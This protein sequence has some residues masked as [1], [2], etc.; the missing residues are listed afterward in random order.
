MNLATLVVAAV[1]AVCG[2]HVESHGVSVDLPARWQPATHSLTPQLLDPHELLSAGTFRL[3]YRELGCTQFPSSALLDLGPADALVT[4]QERHAR[5]HFSKR[6]AHFGPLPNDRSEA[7][8]CVPKARF[9]DH[10]QQFRD[11]G[12]SFHVLVAFGPRAS[13]KTRRDAWAILDSLVVRRR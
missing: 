11:H 1:A 5:T 10:W 4:V 7:S 2:Q 9:T 6:P 13:A 3:R 12:R 8:E